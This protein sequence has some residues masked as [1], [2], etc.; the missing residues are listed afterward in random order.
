MDVSKFCQIHGDHFSSETSG[1][2]AEE[3]G[4]YG[5]LLTASL[6]VEWPLPD[7]DPILARVTGLSL[8]KWKKMRQKV[9]A[10]FTFLDG[11]FYH[12]RVERFLAQQKPNC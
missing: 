2:T 6:E 5:K 11:H 3:A 8:R 1:F 9:L 7:C 4:A 10:L 12:E